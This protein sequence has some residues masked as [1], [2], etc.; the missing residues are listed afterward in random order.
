MDN[1]DNKSEVIPFGWRKRPSCSCKRS[2]L[3]WMTLLIGSV[4]GAC[5]SQGTQDTGNAVDITGTGG[6]PMSSTTQYG[7]QNGAAY[8]TGGFS[9]TSPSLTGGV[10]S[11]TG[12]ASSTG[13]TASGVTAC[14]GVAY[15]PNTSGTGEACTGTGSEAEPSP[16][17]IMMLVDRTQSMTNALS[18]GSGR[19]RWQALRAAVGAFVVDPSIQDIRVGVQFF[20]LSGGADNAT[21]C[22]ANNYATPA[23]QVGPLSQTSQQ[24][25]ST[26]DALVLGGQTPSMPALQGAI[27]HAQD[28]Q[29]RNTPGRRTIVLMVTD[30]LPT[31]CPIPPATEPSS[32]DVAAV[33]AA[34]LGGD[35]SI[36]T[37][38]IGVAIGAGRF[39]LNRVAQAGGS[40]AAFLT[41][42]VPGEDTATAIAAALKN[43]TSDPLACEYQLPPSPDPLKTL[44]T[45]RVRLIHTDGSR[46]S[47]EVPF[48]ETRG[49]CSGAHGGWYYDT[50][51]QPTKIL[52]CP[53][54]CANFKAGSVSIEI[55]CKPAPVTLG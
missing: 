13:A 44:D 24:I 11:G 32:E 19:N 3:V 20:N 34:G 50:P 37:Y 15:T 23:V 38:V 28:W 7:G 6:R 45:T 2:A 1:N 49:G 25:L 27:W 9:T 53:C 43:I 4:G 54:T 41:G 51:T 48:A 55:G 22:N 16:L 35:P 26:M 46:K 52:T 21:D 36:P 12:A 29:K 30:G 47:Y 40:V 5:S 33:A 17:D 42:D 8:S 18:D 39:N 31:L 10:G 14:Q